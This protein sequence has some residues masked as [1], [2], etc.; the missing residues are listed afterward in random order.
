MSG[1]KPAAAK[2]EVEFPVLMNKVW[3]WWMMIEG[4]RPQSMTSRPA[5]ISMADLR[6]FFEV[7][8][9]VPAAWQVELLLKIDLLARDAASEK[10]EEA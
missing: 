2:I 9:I 4:A 7:M 10:V 1:R 3:T 8:C 5:A 6:A